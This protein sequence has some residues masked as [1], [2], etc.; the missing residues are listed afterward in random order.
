MGIEE[1]GLMSLLDLELVHYKIKR[2]GVL[3]LT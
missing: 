2:K 1:D 3:K